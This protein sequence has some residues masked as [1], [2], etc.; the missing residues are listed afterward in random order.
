MTTNKSLIAS[1]L[2]E[3]IF[4]CKSRHGFA[5]GVAGDNKV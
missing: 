3:G 4:I 5:I 1:T 2:T